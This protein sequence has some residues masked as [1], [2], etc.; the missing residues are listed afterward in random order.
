MGIEG[1]ISSAMARL[2][3]AQDAGPTHAES[4]KTS[5][6]GRLLPAVLAFH[7]RQGPL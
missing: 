7:Q 1:R 4:R 5:M 3:H 2:K 6:D